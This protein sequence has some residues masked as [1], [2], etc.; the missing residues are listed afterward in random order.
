MKLI[1]TLI[2]LIYV[3]LFVIKSTLGFAA[4]IIAAIGVLLGAYFAVKR[5]ETTWTARTRV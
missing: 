5:V 4:S 2:L 3:V 1:V